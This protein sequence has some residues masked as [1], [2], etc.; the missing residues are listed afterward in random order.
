MQTTGVALRSGRTGAWSVG[1]V[2]ASD[3]VNMGQ[4]HSQQQGHAPPAIDS[5]EPAQASAVAQPEGNAAAAAQLS[6]GS[7]DSGTPVLDQAADP[8]VHHHGDPA[9]FAE[10]IDRNRR[11]HQWAAEI[12]SE[13]K[14]SP[15]DG[16]D[17]H[18]RGNVLRNTAQ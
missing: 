5:A 14:G 9:T 17:P 15:A 6:G 12:V 4:G 1:Y 13:N 16:T 2:D 18:S 7:G 8:P 11:A 3:E 10:A